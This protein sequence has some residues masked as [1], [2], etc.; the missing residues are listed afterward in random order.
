MLG[1]ATVFLHPNTSSWGPD[2]ET[3]IYTECQS[4]DILMLSAVQDVTRPGPGPPAD[5]GLF[6]PYPNK[7]VHVHVPD[8]HSQEPRPAPPT[9]TKL[10]TTHF[11]SVSLKHS[12]LAGAIS[13]RTGS[14]AE[15][16]I[17]S[18]LM[19]ACWELTSRL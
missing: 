8:K 17:Y 15:R 1:L 13:Q 11:L 18:L 7:R 10:I 9:G 12:F 4:V 3:V 6:L 19:T 16:Q 2:V 5:L 14:Q